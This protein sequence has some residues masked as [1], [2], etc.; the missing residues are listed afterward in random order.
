MGL[1]MLK[2]VCDV[3]GVRERIYR[4]MLDREKGACGFEHLKML[5][6]GIK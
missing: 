4:S 3:C 2:G 1:A 5:N 6:E